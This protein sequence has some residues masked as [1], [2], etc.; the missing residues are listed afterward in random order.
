[1]TTIKLLSCTEYI[2]ETV[3]CVWQASRNPDFHMTPAGVAKMIK[4]AD[5][6]KE[7][8]G[9]LEHE[10]N[11]LFHTLIYDHLPIAEMIDFIFW[12]DD[13]PI[14]LR[15]QMVRHRIGTKIGG[16]PYVDIIPNQAESTWW[17]QGM[18]VLDMSDFAE[19]KDY[20][21]PESIRGDLDLEC[22]LKNAMQDA[23]GH[24]NALIAE[25]IPREDARQVIPLGAT[26]GLAWKLNLQSIKHI[27]GHRSCWILQLGMWEPVIIGMIEELVKI[28]PAFRGLA[29]PPCIKDD[30]YHKCV[31]KVDNERRID[32]EDQPP[33]CSLYVH[34]ERRP[35]QNKILHQLD[36]TRYKMYLTQQIKYGEL[37]KRDTLTGEVL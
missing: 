17:A 36:N 28:D 3:Y 1:M 25:G 7:Q 24:Y 20:H 15:E 21:T 16:V 5:T 9:T 8:V 31:F 23:E 12:L 22:I 34:Q 35:D 32:G 6:P 26:H 37:W 14:S 30:K 2:K 27:I 33:P 29:N 11:D 13:V 18:R 10:V 19:N 4:D